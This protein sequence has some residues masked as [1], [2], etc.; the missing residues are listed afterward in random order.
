MP[1]CTGDLGGGVRH[2]GV[3]AAGGDDDGVDV[4]WLQPRLGQG[5]RTGPGAHRDDGVVL[6]GE[7]PLGDPDPAADPLVVGVHDLRQLVVGDDPVG[8]EMA[9]SGDLGEPGEPATG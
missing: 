6:A 8:P 1:E 4:R 7:P 5:L 2:L 9:E 3:Q